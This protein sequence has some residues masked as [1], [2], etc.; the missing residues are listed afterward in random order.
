MTGAAGEP[1]V[2]VGTTRGGRRPWTLRRRL[3]VTVV[4]LLAATA[5][6]LAITSTLA[7]RAS[8]VSQL[9]TE[10]LAASQRSAGAPRDEP[11]D[12]HH[13]GAATSP[14]TDGERHDEGPT[15]PFLVVA[16]QRTGT[17]GLLSDDGAVVQ[18]G[19]L[20]P[21][22]QVQAIDPEQES[23]L[24]DVPVGA[25]P[26]TVD[27][28]DLGE[29]R[30]VSRASAG[31]E[32]LV[33]GLSLADVRATERDYLTVVALVTL[34]GL[35]A[36]ATAA[37]VVV[38]RALRPLDRMAAAATRV[39]EL[40]LDRGEV[41]LDERVADADT[42]PRTE[43]GQVGASFNHMLGN[44]E[45]ALEAR[46]AS[47]TQVRQFVADASHEL[48][49]PLASIRGYAE[50]V[51]RSPDDV[52]ASTLRALDRVESEAVRMTALVE[53]LL[54]LARLD[55]GR[56][57]ASEEV[58]VAS[59]AVDA[60]TDAHA[61]GPDHEWRLDLPDEPLAV[62]G[63]AA[64]L[65]QVLTNL[66]A[67]ARVHT[68]PGTRVELR[69]SRSGTSP[70]GRQVLIEVRDDGPGIPASLLPTLFQRFTRGDDARNR[71]G[72]STGLGLAIAH[73]V[74]TAHRGTIAV[75]SAPGTTT[76]SVTLPA[77]PVPEPPSGPLPPPPS[78]ARTAR[79]R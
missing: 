56:P 20:D 43:I 63:D 70:S 32:V 18:S 16:G 6:A 72:G 57:L 38:R 13:G 27:L 49:T 44:V 19:F 34:L 71:A 1:G 29:F 2:T 78:A 36:A 40:P 39:A 75:E 73:A 79:A 69:V 51:R 50:L 21:D 3:V 47:E 48:R 67:N 65:H 22:A 53:D 60:L 35:L 42:D 46:H 52:P 55:A 17:V 74:V 58:D 8:L 12:D 61:A 31:Q 4:L 11:G 59:L 25:D 23:I 9:D 10:L 77:A 68:P 26:L 15:P 64:R 66:L 5:G 45:R 33:T 76:F 28:T 7:L 14:G 41:S 54:L 24:L 62:V 30:V 37:A